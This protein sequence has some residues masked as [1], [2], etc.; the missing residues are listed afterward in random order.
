MTLPSGYLGQIK[1][2]ESHSDF[3]RFLDQKKLL[4]NRNVIE[5]KERKIMDAFN[6]LIKMH[7]VLFRPQIPHNTGAI[8]RTCL[9]YGAKLHLIGPLGFS[10]EDTQVKR[11]GL[12]YWF[13]LFDNPLIFRQHVDREFYKDW[14]SFEA[15]IPSLGNCTFLFS[16]FLSFCIETIRPDSKRTIFQ[17]EEP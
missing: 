11:A 7:I 9:G 13:L 16:T 8:G 15:A 12:D 10:L 14:E 1:S 6:R 4:Y 2:A 5:L 3:P 17:R